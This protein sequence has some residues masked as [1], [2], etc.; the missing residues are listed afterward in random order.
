MRRQPA[1]WSCISQPPEQWEGKKKKNVYCLIHPACGVLLW[2]PSWQR[3]Q[4]STSHTGGYICSY[5]HIYFYFMLSYTVG[6]SKAGS[7]W[8]PDMETCI[9]ISRD[10]LTFWSRWAALGPAPHPALVSRSRCTYVGDQ[11]LQLW[12]LS[13]NKGALVTLCLLHT[14]HIL[15]YRM[16]LI[17]MKGKGVKKW[18]FEAGQRNKESKKD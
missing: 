17:S 5:K 14:G 16:F 9:E 10:M 11:L 2:Q 1:P 7:P 3:H 18:H 15:P 13:P 8:L 6:Y 12:A 4:V